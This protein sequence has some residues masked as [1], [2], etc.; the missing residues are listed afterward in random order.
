M[1]TIETICDENNPQDRK[2]LLLARLVDSQFK[3][4][5]KT[6]DDMT[7]KQD[8]METILSELVKKIDKEIEVIS[9]S[10]KR[11]ETQKKACPVY[12]NMPEAS[13]MIEFAKNPNTEKII[14]FVKNPKMA[15]YASIGGAFA[16]GIF[17]SGGI[18]DAV[19]Y[20][21]KLIVK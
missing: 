17:S 10:V 21:I 8:K 18:R 19:Y 1:D 3:E 6:Q 14:F 4:I 16:L 7:E 9:N 12:N 15:I 13:K 2:Q 20:I 5:R 11:L